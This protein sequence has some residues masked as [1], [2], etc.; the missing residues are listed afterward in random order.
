MTTALLEIHGER[1]AGA[2]FE[3]DRVV[4]TIF[5]PEATG[6]GDYACRVRI[7]ALFREDRRI[8]GVDAEQAK[9]LAASFVHE[10]LQGY[11]MSTVRPTA[12]RP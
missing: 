3:A 4:A 7:P 12:E 1:E 6:E 5:A 9:T 11:R 8:F 10:L 2:A